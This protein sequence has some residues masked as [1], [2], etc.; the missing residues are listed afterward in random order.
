MTS[1][2]FLVFGRATHQT[3]GGSISQPGGLFISR[4]PARLPAAYRKRESNLFFMGVRHE[5]EERNEEPM[6]EVAPFGT[7]DNSELSRSAVCHDTCKRRQRP[8]P[9]ST[10][11]FK[12]LA[13]PTP[14]HSP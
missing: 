9:G 4:P 8:G 2:F 10:T 7:P 11:S 5:N 14:G 6:R 3:W 13:L 12:Y 1:I